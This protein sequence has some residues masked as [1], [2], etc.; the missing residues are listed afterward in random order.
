MLHVLKFKVRSY[1]VW[2]W[3]L[4]QKPGSSVRTVDRQYL[5]RPV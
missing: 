4:G 3:E 5:Y 1:I 2:G